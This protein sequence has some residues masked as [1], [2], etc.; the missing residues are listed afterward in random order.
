MRQFTLRCL[1]AAAAV[2]TVVEFIARQIGR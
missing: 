2:I 1:M